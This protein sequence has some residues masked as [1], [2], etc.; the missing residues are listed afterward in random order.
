[1][2]PQ[3]LLEH[4]PLLVT[5]PNGGEHYLLEWH[6]YN[7]QWHVIVDRRESHILPIVRGI[8]ADNDDLRL[9]RYLQVEIVGPSDGQRLRWAQTEFNAAVKDFWA[10]VYLMLAGNSLNARNLPAILPPDLMRCTEWDG[11][12]GGVTAED[13]WGHGWC[14]NCCHGLRPRVGTLGSVYAEKK[15]VFDGMIKPRSRFRDTD[16]RVVSRARPVG[17]NEPLWRV[18]VGA[19]HHRGTRVTGKEDAHDTGPAVFFY[20]SPRELDRSPLDAIIKAD[21]DDRRQ[22]R[23]EFD[24]RT[25]IAFQ[26]N[27]ERISREQRSLLDA[28]FPPGKDPT[29]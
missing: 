11:G 23:L 22:K 15:P 29:A 2:D 8:L 20:T 28:L 27:R 24:Q 10:D 6:T 13:D 7:D 16:N 12:E 17:E 21:Q 25:K 26:E 18:E 19:H 14:L 3:Y 9:G 5:Y 1:M 4:F